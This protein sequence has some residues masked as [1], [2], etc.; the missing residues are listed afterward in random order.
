MNFVVAKSV[1]FCIGFQ[2]EIIMPV[3]DGSSENALQSHYW[4]SS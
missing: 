3:V 1:E 4:K 2:V